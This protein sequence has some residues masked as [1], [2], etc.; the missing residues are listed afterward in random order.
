MA[1]RLILRSE[2]RNPLS[3][4]EDIDWAVVAQNAAEIIRVVPFDLQ[5]GQSKT[6]RRGMQVSL[7][8]G[9]EKQGVIQ[10]TRPH[11]GKS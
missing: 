5:V 7:I 8:D 6:F 11:R 1:E 3:G 4:P 10:A 2:K 9:N